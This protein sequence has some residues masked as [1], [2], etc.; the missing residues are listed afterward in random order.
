M[1]NQKVDDAVF[2][3][4]LKQACCDAFAQ[5]IEQ[6]EA[7]DDQPAKPSE[8][9]RKQERRYYRKFQRKPVKAATILRGTAACLV[10]LMGLSFCL[11]MTSAP[12][13]A[14]MVDTV[15]SLFEKYLTVDLSEAEDAVMLGEH[16]MGYVPKDFALVETY[17]MAY[18]DLYI[19]SNGTEKFK[20]YFYGEKDFSLKYDNEQTNLT[21]IDINDGKGY[22]VNREDGTCVLFWNLNDHIVSIESNLN[23]NI[24]KKIA[25]NIS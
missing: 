10:A 23:L 1:I 2:D 9:Q 22:F 19:F 3:V 14:A 24:L 12:V 20:V 5:E 16:T 25:K 6:I 13:R 21:L 15:V 11:M 7:A 8:V 17:E 4:I 18:F